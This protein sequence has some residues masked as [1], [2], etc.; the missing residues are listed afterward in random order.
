VTGYK[1]PRERLAAIL[2]ADVVGY[3]RL[4][5]DDERTT[6]ATLDEYREVFRRKIE[7]H[8]G[9]IVDMAGDSIL[10]VFESVTGA[11]QT[12]VDVQIALAKHNE[13]LPEDRRMSFRVGVNLGDILEKEDGTI[14]GDGVN[15]AARLETMASPGGINVSGAVFNSVRAKIAGPFTFLGEHELKNIVE[16][17]AVYRLGAGGD[18]SATRDHRPQAVAAE[19]AALPTIVVKPLKV[20]SGGEE[21]ESLAA[22]LHQDIVGALTKQTAIDVISSSSGGGP[23]AAGH[24]LHFRLEGNIRAVGQRLRLA[25]TLVDTVLERQIWSEHYDRHLEDIF[26]LEDEISRNVGSAVRIR[27][28]AHTFERLCDANNDELTVPELLS[29]V[30]GYFVDSYRHNEEAAATLQVAMDREPD[31]SMAIAMRVFCSHRSFEFSVFDILQDTKK[32]FN[33][34]LRRAL[35]L[36]PSSY[37]AHLIAAMIAQDV[38]GDY[39][40]ALGHAETSL[41]LNSGFSPATAMVGIAKIHLGDPDLGLRILRSG[42]DAAP[43]DPHRFRNRRELAVGYFV[44]ADLPAA[45]AVIDRLV[46]QAPDLLRNQL[47]LVPILWHAG[48]EDEANQYVRDV[49]GEH[50]GLNQ[51][52][53][54]PTRIADPHVAARFGEGLTL[55]GLPE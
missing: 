4:M 44:S 42:I 52:N 30:A 41:E 35:S 8:T 55:A 23:S 14:Y 48:R 21:I 45:A 51:R 32:E 24:G 22:G 34:R 31:N 49:L 11:V 26:E 29:K 10:A 12:A 13:A 36:D 15:V 20:I 5:R 47:V 1:E 3:S 6:V 33:A 38:A 46:H 37:F 16:P 54:R 18:D 27:I 53:M 19:T 43:E 9:R 17:V 50:P 7:A 25:F 2:V 40:T 28:K 39:E